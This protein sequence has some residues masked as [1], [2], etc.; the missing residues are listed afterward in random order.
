M[1][2]SS[3]VTSTRCSLCWSDYSFSL[4]LSPAR[5]PELNHR[6]C[7][8]QCDTLHCSCCAMPPRIA[9]ILP[10]QVIGA[11]LTQWMEGLRI[12]AM[13]TGCSCNI[14]AIGM[15]LQCWSNI[16]VIDCIVVIP[17]GIAATSSCSP[18]MYS[19]VPQIRTTT[20]AATSPEHLNQLALFH[21]SAGYCDQ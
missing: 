16:V 15:Q 2:F 11:T 13:R 14:A 7:A 20:P 17:P 1:R 18:Q 4:L 19:Q 8:W 6:H 5:W 9:A 12:D 21:Q 3:Y 10:Q